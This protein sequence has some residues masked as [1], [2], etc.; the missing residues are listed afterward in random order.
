MG[1]IWKFVTTPDWFHGGIRIVD[2]VPILLI[3]IILVV[4]WPDSNG[5][6]A[7][8]WFVLASVSVCLTRKF[9]SSVKDD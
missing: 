8:V 5:W 3:G 6:A 2:L 1:R 7:L 4:V 9:I